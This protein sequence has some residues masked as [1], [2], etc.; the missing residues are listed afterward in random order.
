MWQN[1]VLSYS[2]VTRWVKQFNGRESDKDLKRNGRP[3]TISDSY[4]V[5]KVMD[6][7][8]VRGGDVTF[9]AIRVRD[10]AAFTLFS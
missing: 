9:K 5:E 10:F 6:A 4:N 3:V 2:Q 1:N 7:T 8:C